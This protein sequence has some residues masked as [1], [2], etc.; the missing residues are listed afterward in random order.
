MRD[1]R[2][3]SREANIN[4]RVDSR[5]VPAPGVLSLSFGAPGGLG[6]SRLRTDRLT[7]NP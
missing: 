3:R 6:L 1:A 5:A 7:I 4:R 2:G